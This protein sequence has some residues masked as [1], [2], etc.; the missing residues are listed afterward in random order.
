MS[1]IEGKKGHNIDI[2]VRIQFLL[3]ALIIFHTKVHKWTPFYSY[4][5]SGFGTK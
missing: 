4:G 3:V 1:E 2:K 5:K